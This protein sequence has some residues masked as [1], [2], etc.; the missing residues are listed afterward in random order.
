MHFEIPKIGSLIREARVARKLSQLAL[1]KAI[2]V[3]ARTISA[4]ETDRSHPTYD[5][6]YKLVRFLDLPVE[7]IFWPGEITYT[8][9]QAQLFQAIVSCNERD[10][11]IFMNI[12]WAFIRSL[13]K[14]EIP[15]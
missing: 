7:H 4:I 1:A 14:D 5:V 12:A 8:S 10:K 9:E 3:S 2:G 11:A 6:L 15:K 13:E